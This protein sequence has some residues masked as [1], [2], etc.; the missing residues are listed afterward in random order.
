LAD[1]VI[2]MS[3]RPGRIVRDDRV[4]IARPRDI[5]FIHGNEEFRRLYD[6]IWHELAVQVHEAV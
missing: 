1:R 3:A 4:A 5:F 2:L 6:E